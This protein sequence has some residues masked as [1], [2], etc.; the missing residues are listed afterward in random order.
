MLGETAPGFLPAAGLL[1]CQAA[2]LLAPPAAASPP[3]SS[4]RASVATRAAELAADGSQSTLQR[5]LAAE[6][7][8]ALA[9]ALGEA[10]ELASAARAASTFC[11]LEVQVTALLAAMRY[12][13]T[14]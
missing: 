14:E 2:V 10:P 5:L 12:A 13:R 9:G 1:H 11:P 7:V 4:S 6:W 8:H 3:S